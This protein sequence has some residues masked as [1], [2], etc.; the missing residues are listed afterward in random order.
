VEVDEYAV[1]LPLGAVDANVERAAVALKLV[2]LDG[3]DLRAGPL[4]GGEGCS[5]SSGLR[6]RDFPRRLTA[7]FGRHLK[8]ILGR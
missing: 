5:R 6:Q 4:H 8:E 2:F 7:C 3:L 1:G